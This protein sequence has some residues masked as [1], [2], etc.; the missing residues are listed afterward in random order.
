MSGLTGNNI[1][2]GSSG[3]GDTG[4][5]IE[6]SVVFDTNSYFTRTPSSSGNQKTWTWSSW[7]KIS[8][9]GDVG[10]QDVLLQCYQDNANRC[11]FFIGDNATN[12]IAFFGKTGNTNQVHLQTTAAYRDYSGWYHLMVVLDTTQS[13]ASNRAKI[14][15]NGEQ[16][17]DFSTSVYPN[18][19]DDLTINKNLEH[20]IGVGKWNS[21]IYDTKYHGYMAEVHFIDGTALTPASFGETDANTNQ[22]KPIKYEGSYGTNGF[23][24][25]FATRATD[26]IDASGNGND[27]SSTNV[28][29]GDW[30]IDSPTNNFC[31]INPIDRGSTLTGTFS[32]GNTRVVINSDLAV[33]GTIMYPKTGKWYAECL[34]KDD[35]KTTEWGFRDLSVHGYSTKGFQIYTS[36]TVSQLRIRKDNVTVASPSYPGV[37]AIYSIAY[38]ADTGDVEAFVNGSSVYSGTLGTVGIDYI[39]H[40]L[41]GS[42]DPSFYSD[43]VVNYGQDSSFA[44]NK[45]AQNN[46]DGNGKGDFYYTPPSGY[47]ALCEDNLPDPSIALPGDHF[48][49]V[50][51]VGD[52]NSTQEVTT[53]FQP[54]LIWN[55]NRTTVYHHRFFDRVRG[56]DK[57]VYSNNNSAEDTYQDYGYPTAT[58]STSVTVGRGTDTN[59][60]INL[61]NQN[62]VMW[63]WKADNTSGSSNTDG[64]ITSTVS[65]NPT[66]GFSI[67]KYTGNA[68]AGATVGHGLSQAPDFMLVKQLDAV[69][70]WS[71]YYGDPTDYLILN[72]QNATADDDRFWNDTS[73]GAS[74]FTLGGLNW[75][76]ASGNDY[77]AYCFHSVEGYS[78]IGSYTGNG[79]TD[80]PFIYTG[81]RPAFV[82]AKRTDSS[83]SWQMWDNARDIDN[84]VTHR[85]RA[86]LSNVEDT[87]GVDVDFLSNGW[88]LRN[89]GINFSSGTYIYMAF[90]ESPFKYSNAR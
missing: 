31:T 22:W 20:T 26:P 50:V 40:F 58:S 43:I 74:V 89:T 85:L 8:P 82:M 29:A 87:G 5:N 60:L 19:N 35:D 76:N 75:V 65:A 61:N 64:T 27:W 15:I 68:T 81:F 18:Q 39:P 86:D 28:I 67:V 16:V 46:T 1:L 9:A 51:Y 2:A 78:K 44:G 63:N 69:K 13:T 3:Q 21:A 59:N 90:A 23:F 24:L 11:G 32:E 48:E 56:L 33:R 4:Y 10:Q 70:N 34:Y 84:V 62:Y 66:A 52:G 72:G 14:Y 17:T 7:I 30:K 57:S 71:V 54:D 80:G 12:Y 88:K 42:S 77:I 47:L 45:T 37:N 25:D 6:R 53:D 83:S 41:H 73:P 36:G 38:D 79:A 55:K 49:A